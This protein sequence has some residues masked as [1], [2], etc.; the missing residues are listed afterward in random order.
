MLNGLLTLTHLSSD[1]PHILDGGGATLIDVN[2]GAASFSCSITS[3]NG[4]M[5]YTP[6]GFREAVMPHW[7]GNASGFP[8]GH[9]GDSFEIYLLPATY[10]SGPNDEE[11]YQSACKATGLRTVTTS[12]INNWQGFTYCSVWDCLRTSFD[13]DFWTGLGEATGW[14]IIDCQRG[15][16]LY[17]GG[18]TGVG[19]V[20]FSPF[21]TGSN[22]GLMNPVGGRNGKDNHPGVGWGMVNPVCGRTVN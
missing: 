6:P 20:A 22:A 7:K 15:D 19:A 16:P 13:D 9:P 10:I 2:F 14:D 12:G 4:T 8:R 1:F 3:E 21:D 17:G 5:A 11:T 18:C